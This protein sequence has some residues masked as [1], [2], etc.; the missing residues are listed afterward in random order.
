MI[1]LKFQLF[2]PPAFDKNSLIFIFLCFFLLIL[3]TNFR[4]LEK[5]QRWRKL[6][7]SLRVQ[8]GLAVMETE[9]DEHSVEEKEMVS[10]C[11]TGVSWMLETSV[12]VCENKL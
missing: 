5:A 6:K 11:Q 1:S 8:S 12:D 10:E 2:L 7:K 4:E 9:M 3:F